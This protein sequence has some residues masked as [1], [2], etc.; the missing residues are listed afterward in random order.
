MKQKAF[1]GKLIAIDMY[2]CGM[3]EISTATVAEE[4]LRKGCEEFAMHCQQI[5][6]Y[7]EEGAK[8]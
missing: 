4:L 1:L 6:S 2:N 3:E 7:Q 5:V 8:E